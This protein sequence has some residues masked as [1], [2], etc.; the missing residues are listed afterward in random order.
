MAVNTLSNT[1]FLAHQLFDKQ[2]SLYPSLS[3]EGKLLREVKELSQ[4]HKVYIMEAALDLRPLE[5]LSRAAT[6][7]GVLKP[8]EMLLESL[9]IDPLFHI[10]PE[11]Y[12]ALWH[13]NNLILPSISI[14]SDRMVYQS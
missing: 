1:H 13:S 11:S 3:D 14:A 6:P 4:G 12:T 5:A 10:A 2:S 8:L 7:P 9:D